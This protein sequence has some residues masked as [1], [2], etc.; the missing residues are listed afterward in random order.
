MSGLMIDFPLTPSKQ[1]YPG[2]KKN[3]RATLML[4]FGLPSANQH[5]WCQQTPETSERHLLA[6]KIHVGDFLSEA[7][8]CALQSSG[9]V[10][11]KPCKESKRLDICNFWN[12]HQ[13]PGSFDTR[14]FCL[15]LLTFD[16]PGRLYF[17]WE[18]CQ[19]VRLHFGRW[20][21]YQQ[22]TSHITSYNFMSLPHPQCL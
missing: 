6:Q 11:S 10:H 22:G 15:P 5:R 17:V 9:R 16:C 3:R 1:V 8:L 21:T 4:A 14:K 2:K 12:I 18:T 20:W 19:N 7:A 13:L